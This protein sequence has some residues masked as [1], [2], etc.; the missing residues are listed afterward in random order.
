[1]YAAFLSQLFEMNFGA[2][3]GNLEGITHEQ[4]LV[5]PQPEGNCI[6]WVL[7]HM[8]ASRSRILPL[9]EVQPPWDSEL[10]F[11]YSG[12]P[13][14][15]WSTA[16]AIQLESIKVDYARSQQAI[17][18]ALHGMTNAKLTK[19]IKGKPLL[20]VLGF[21]HFHETYHVGQIGLLRRIVGHHGVIKPPP[22]PSTTIA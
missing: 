13:E 8:V 22:L 18:T 21:A 3:S 6:N 10:S 14:A 4:S 1:M 7:G 15:E 17:L 20:E 5:L 9:L 16:R 12:R 19:A 2:L 11:L